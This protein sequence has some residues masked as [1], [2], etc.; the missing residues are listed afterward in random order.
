MIKIDD[1]SKC[2]GCH[3]CYNICPKSAVTMVRDKEGFLYPSVN[4]NC[5]DCGLCEKVCQYINPIVSDSIGKSYGCYNNNSDVRKVSSS[6]GIFTLIS[7]Y[8]INKGG[9]VFG[10]AFN[11]SFEVSHT[12]ISNAGDIQRL[13][14]SKYTQ[15]EIGDIYKQV[16]DCLEG[17]QYVLFSGTPCQVDGLLHYLNRRYDRLYTQDIVCHG[18]PSP[19]VWKMYL[20]HIEQ[21]NDD[22]VEK[23]SFRCKDSGWKLY[24]VAFDF[25]KKERKSN[26]YTDDLFM[27]AFLKDICLRPSCYN[28]ASKT[29]KRTSDITLADFWGVDKLLPELF[30]D[31]GTSL[32]F[33][34]S[35]KGQE[36]FS[37][38]KKSA[39][40]R[41]VDIN[42]AVK[43]NTSAYK[44]VQMPNKRDKFMRKISAEN[45]DRV[46]KKYTQI[47]FKN[48]VKYK[49]KR[50]LNKNFP[51]I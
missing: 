19:K 39:T 11:D 42:D 21:K 16:K 44:S 34:N 27:K 43:Y 36:L 26:V 7:E 22:K 45:F 31:K 25:L 49:I 24:S 14:G 8:I 47:S 33:V 9:V 50:L 38:V 17:D 5:V 6:G 1:K 15:S 2:S 35:E 51:T 41:E 29:L 10:A 4:D 32:V 18:V 23:I 3:A 37:S 48:R 20:E 46:V 12:V 40:C 28:C 13:R 30:D